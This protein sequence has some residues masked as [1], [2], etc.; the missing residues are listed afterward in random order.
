MSRKWQSQNSNLKCWTQKPW[1]YLCTMP[2]LHSV[3]GS[4]CCQLKPS[5]PLRTLLSLGPQ[6]RRLLILPWPVYYKG[7]WE[8]R[9]QQSMA[10]SR[11]LLFHPWVTPAWDSYRQA[12]KTTTPHCCCLL[13]TVLITQ[14]TEFF[15]PWRPPLV[16]ASSSSSALKAFATLTPM[17]HSQ[18]WDCSASGVR[19]LND[20][21]VC[22][23]THV[24]IHYKFYW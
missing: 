8:T 20:V 1:S 22:V 17:I 6:K 14:C 16:I 18:E 19:R 11:L 10:M 4:C 15:G 5:C 9:A 24:I 23:P 21:C 13:L 2:P 3:R 12:V 7:Q